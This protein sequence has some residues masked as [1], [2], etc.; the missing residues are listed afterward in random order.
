MT[1][2]A[3]GPKI[4]NFL[5]EGVRWDQVGATGTMNAARNS[6]NTALNNARAASSTMRGIAQIES[7]EA[8]ADAIRAGGQAAGQASAVSGIASGI[9]GLG[10]LFKRG[11]GSSFGS[12]ALS[13]GWNMGAGLAPL[14][15]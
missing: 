11:G 10:G 8:Q 7:A 5:D 12:T 13:S 4:S 2:F 9:G 15:K 14:V 6:A 1:R 3:G